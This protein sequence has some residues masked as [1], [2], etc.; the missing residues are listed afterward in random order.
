MTT[1][2]TLDDP[3]KD[4]VARIAATNLTLVAL[5]KPLPNLSSSTLFP[6]KI[7]LRFSRLLAPTL[8]RPTS[9]LGLRTPHVTP[10]PTDNL[11]TAPT[12]TTI[13][14]AQALAQSINDAANSSPAVDIPN[15][16]VA[17]INPQQLS[18]PLEVGSSCHLPSPSGS[19]RLPLDIH[20]TRGAAASKNKEPKGK[21]KAV[22]Q[23]EASEDVDMADPSEELVG[24]IRNKT[25]GRTLA[26]KR[27]YSSRR[28]KSLSFS[29]FSYCS[30]YGLFLL[31][32][33]YALN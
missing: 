15:R 29:S 26:N 7:V 24:F 5:G 9:R 16:A 3:T 8:P 6:P 2:V 4:I 11:S 28:T 31:S 12:P 14:P 25:L 22:E 1:P 21:A 10:T 32:H 13:T 23:T 33:L 18:I 30:L 27:C 20:F 19:R 17:T